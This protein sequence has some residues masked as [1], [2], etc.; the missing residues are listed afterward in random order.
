MSD[1]GSA[2]VVGVPLMW[3]LAFAVFAYVD[4]PSHGLRARKWGLI[5]L[6]IPILGLFAY[7][8]ERSEVYYDPDDDPYRGGGINIHE[9]AEVHPEAGDEKPDEW[10]EEWDENLG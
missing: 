7:L 9:D 6:L 10:D 4:A 2:L 8:F 1:L 5:V 3:H